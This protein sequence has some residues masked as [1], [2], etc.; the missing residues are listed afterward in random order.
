MAKEKDFNEYSYEEL[1]N[2]LTGMALMNIGA[3]ES[4]RSTVNMVMSYTNQWTWK[5]AEDKLK[6]K[7][8]K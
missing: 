2:Y 1:L 8:E 7:G 5:I 6:E 3:G 4:L